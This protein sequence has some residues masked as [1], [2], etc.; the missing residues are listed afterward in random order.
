M[1]HLFSI[2]SPV[3]TKSGFYFNILFYHYC[4]NFG[5]GSRLRWFWYFIWWFVFVFYCL[6]FV[7]CSKCISNGSLSYRRINIA[8]NKPLSVFRQ[9]SQQ[10]CKFVWITT[11]VILGNLQKIYSRDVL[12][13]KTRKCVKT[14]RSAKF[15]QMYDSRYCL[16][17]NLHEITRAHLLGSVWARLRGLYKWVNGYLLK[18]SV[19][20][21]NPTSQTNTLDAQFFFLCPV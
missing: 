19:F 15:L 14:C 1:Y 7:W 12:E 18:S 9:V 4:Q 6:C 8:L 5:A 2:F 17:H 3:A 11:S 20:C 13:E 10:C 21:Y 16:F